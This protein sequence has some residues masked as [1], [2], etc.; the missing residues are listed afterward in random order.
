MKL[1]ILKTDTVAPELADQ[2]GQY[3]EMFARLLA[4]DSTLELVSFDVMNGEY[5]ADID[6]VDAYLITGSRTTNV[7]CP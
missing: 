5:P 1:G 3:P 4:L 6:D 2:F 7:I